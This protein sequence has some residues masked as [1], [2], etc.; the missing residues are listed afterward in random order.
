MKS[1]F[2]LFSIFLSISLLSSCSYPRTVDVAKLASHLQKQGGK[3][4]TPDSTGNTGNTGG[5]DNTDG[6]STTT[7]ALVLPGSG[8]GVTGGPTAPDGMSGSSGISGGVSTGTSGGT[9]G[10][11][12]GG[13]T[14]TGIFPTNPVPT[15]LPSRDLPSRSFLT[16]TNV[17]MAFTTRSYSTPSSL[18]RS[19]VEV[20]R[21]DDTSDGSQTLELTVYHARDDSSTYFDLLSTPYTF[22]DPNYGSGIVSDDRD[23]FLR[24][25]AL[26]YSSLSQIYLGTGLGTSAEI[27]HERLLIPH[28]SVLPE[29]LP[30]GSEVHYS[31][32]W[33]LSPQPA[34]HL[35]KDFG[36]EH[37]NFDL[38]VDF[39]DS[40]GSLLSHVFSGTAYQ[41]GL[42]VGYFDTGSIGSDGHIR[43]LRFRGLDYTSL[44]SLEIP[45]M[46]GG[47]AGPAGQEI[48]AA[49]SGDVGFNRV[50]FGIHGSQTGSPGS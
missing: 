14:S 20:Q 33:H 43:N 15:G 12:S 50:V 47:F 3:P 24:T 2:T 40:S 45:H 25:T 27:T 21:V 29:S 39:S 46:E 44:G 5:T 11:I 41:D 35:D 19:F 9:S 18:P 16:P 36:V 6:D 4:P 17:D 28:V 34:S 38:S 26:D 48:I 49:G 30:R 13:T 37:G 10:G 22:T 7:T 32:N 31:G 8:S 1:V 23:L 42:A